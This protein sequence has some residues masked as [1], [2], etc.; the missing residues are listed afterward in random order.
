M[1]KKVNKVISKTLD[2]PI[3]NVSNEEYTKSL[4]IF[5][6][7]LQKEIENLRNQLKLTQEKENKSS[8]NTNY[9][10][11]AQVFNEAK[12][13]KELLDTLFKKIHKHYSI[14]ELNIYFFDNNHFLIPIIENDTNVALNSQVKRLEEQGIIDFIAEKGDINII[15]NLDDAFKN[16]TTYLIL[17]PIT[18]QATAIGF[19]ISRTTKT[20]SEFTPQELKDLSVV[21]EYAAFAIDN[22]RSKEEIAS[23]NKKL[24]GMNSQILETSKLV[25]L[26]E[27]ATSISME[28]DNPLKIIKSNIDFI[29][30]GLGNSK[31]RIDIIKEQTDK[32]ISLNGKLS[33]LVSDFNEEKS[34][35]IEIKS[36]IDELL[37]LSETQM[38]ESDIKII[39]N[40]EESD[41]IVVTKKS[42][43]EQIFLNVLQFAKESFGDDSGKIEIGI[44]KHKAKFV[45]IVIVDDSIGLDENEQK[46]ILEPIFIKSGKRK[47]G[48]GLYLAN[49]YIKELNGKFSIISELGKGTTY[50]VILPIKI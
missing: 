25:T 47:T 8:S 36:L 45:S 13:N 37:H 38:Q 7:F 39:K 11:I 18:I 22:L 28:F 30:R 10:A 46:T 15:H 32:L 19:F 31:R 1:A 17:V 41:F 12:S 3:N 44:Y 33:Q 34:L 5:V 21:A 16:I 50:K 42:I 29:E 26:G 9:N 4:E 27:L 20:Q 2:A 40:Y 24:I 43:I 35:N 14:L 49:E 23:I 6:N 48:I